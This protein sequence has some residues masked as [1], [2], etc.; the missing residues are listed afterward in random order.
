[1]AHARLPC[2]RGWLG[3]LSPQLTRLGLDIDDAAERCG[4][5]ATLTS[6]RRLDLHFFRPARLGAIKPPHG[7]GTPLYMPRAMDAEIVPYLAS[8][9]GVKD[10]VGAVKLLPLLE[11]VGLP[12]FEK[13]IGEAYA[14]FL[15]LVQKQ[16]LGARS[17]PVA[18][19][20]L[21]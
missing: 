19:V 2:V 9:P 7:Y 13:C 17:P 12:G 20:T 11:Q 5:L 14:E 3:S 6:L 16:L 8:L 15:R 10:I 1:M 4:E 21:D 18:L